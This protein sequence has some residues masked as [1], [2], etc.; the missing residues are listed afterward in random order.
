MKASRIRLAMVVHNYGL[1]GGVEKY[2]AEVTERISQHPEFDVHVFAHR[3]KKFS[4]RVTFHEIPRLSFP[5]SLKPISFA[6][7][8]KR[9]LSAESFDIVHTHERI[10]EADVYSMHGL[11]HHIWSRE[12]KKKIVP[13]LFDRSTAWIEKKLVSSKRCKLLLPVSTLVRDYFKREFDLISKDIQIL[14]PGI[15]LSWFKNDP[16]GHRQATRKRLGLADDD[17]AVLFVGMNFAIKGLDRLLDAVANIKK[18]CSR[19]IRPVIV[20]KG[21]WPKYRRISEK[22]NIAGDIIYLGVI[23]DGLPEIYAACDSFCLLSQSDAFP[24]VVLEAMAGSL[25]V[26]VSENVGAKDAVTPGENGFVV[27]AG[28][29][30]ETENALLALMDNDLRTTMSRN[31]FRTSQ[32]YTWESTVEKLLSFY[33]KML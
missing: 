9:A 4:D 27:D 20:G 6:V 3:W 30:Q 12:I 10:F 29:M 8:A 11:P 18:S 15:D 28:D 1:I 14:H 31:A 33:S 16:I 21:H 5:R 25:P 22:L 2:T 7:S 23:R 19:R 26:I 17:I 13:S 32:A 24:L